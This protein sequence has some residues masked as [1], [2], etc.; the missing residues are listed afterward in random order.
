MGLR[1][2]TTASFS[3]PLTKCRERVTYDRPSRRL[4]A[5]LYYDCAPSWAQQLNACVISF[6]V[7]RA[8]DHAHMPCR[9]ACELITGN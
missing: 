1:N 2:N 9:A 7:N 4:P 3:V 6:A 5:A 8:V